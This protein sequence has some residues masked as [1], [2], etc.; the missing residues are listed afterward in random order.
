[1][2]GWSLCHVSVYV[3]TLTE[4]SKSNDWRHA[5]PY[6]D[7]AFDYMD[8]MIPHFYVGCQK[9]GSPP[10]FR[11]LFNS[12]TLHFVFLSPGLRGPNLF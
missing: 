12:V 11:M 2:F 1:M 9:S 4:F 3:F 8:N 7:M 10:S 5:A 6:Y